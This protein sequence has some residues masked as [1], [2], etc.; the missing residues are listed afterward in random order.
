MFNLSF[1]KT[2]TVDNDKSLAGH[3]NT[4]LLHL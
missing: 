2:L 1:I 4:A 3:E